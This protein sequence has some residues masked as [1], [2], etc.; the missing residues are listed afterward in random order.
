MNKVFLE[1]ANENFYCS[2]ATMRSFFKMSEDIDASFTVSEEDKVSI[3]EEGD[4]IKH[5]PHSRYDV[6][7]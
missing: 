2:T 6:E 1:L 4:N 3:V 7:G 5:N